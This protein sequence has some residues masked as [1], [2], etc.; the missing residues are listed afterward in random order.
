MD[1]NT[2]TKEFFEGV[3]SRMLEYGETAVMAVANFDYAKIAFE[4]RLTHVDGMTLE[5]FVVEEERNG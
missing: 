3:I 1:A 4:I 2:T 5:E